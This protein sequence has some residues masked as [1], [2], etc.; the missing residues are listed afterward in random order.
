M[1]EW[2]NNKYKNLT[3]LYK[4]MNYEYKIIQKVISKNLYL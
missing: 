3:A 4:S 1:K 2:K